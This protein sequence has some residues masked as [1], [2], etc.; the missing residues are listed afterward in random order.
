MH[1]GLILL[2]G[3]ELSFQEQEGPTMLGLQTRIYISAAILMA[4]S[5]ARCSLQSAA[6]DHSGP[7]VLPANTLVM[8]R[9]TKSV[10]KKDAKP[11]K[12]LDF[13]VA[14]DVLVNGLILI[15]SGTHV[16]GS[17]RRVDYSERKRAKILMDLGTVKTVSG[18]TVRLK[19]TGSAGSSNEESDLASVAEAGSPILVPAFA[20]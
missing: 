10:Y 1:P 20:L 16:T 8:L 14:Q 18:E 13:A 19:L 17:V 6:P 11:G 5:Q 2:P 3:I 15:Q 7:L 9:L 4:A 12:P